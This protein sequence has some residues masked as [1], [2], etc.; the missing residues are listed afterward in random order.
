MLAIFRGRKEIPPAYLMAVLM[1]SFPS[2]L[3]EM[4]R[5]TRPSSESERSQQVSPKQSLLAKSSWI[6][7]LILFSASVVAAQLVERPLITARHAVVTS[8][9][10]LASMAGMR[11][12]QEGGN[13]FDAAVATAV[14]VGVL[15]PRMS[16]IGGNGFATIYVGK[17]H[18]VRALDFYGSAPQR[19]TASLYQG[20]DYSHGF[21]SAPVPSSLKGYE[22]LHKAYGK[23]PWARVLQPAIELAEDGFVIRQG[24]INDMKEYQKLLQEFPSTTKVLQPNGRWP[25]AGEIFRQPDLARTLKDIAKNGADAFYRGPL[26]A[27]IAQFYQANG[28]V[29]SA[30]DLAG[31]QAK[32]IAPI[33]TNYRGYIFYTQPPSSSG[34]AVLE[35]L[36]MLE[37]YDLRALGH[38][39]SEYLHLIGEVMRLAIADRN[40]YVGD[41]DF[42]KVPVEKLLSKSYAAERRKLIHL[43]TT[44]PIAT[45][46]DFDQPDDKHTTHLSVVDDDDNMVAL[47]QTLGDIFGSGVIAADTGVFFSDEMRH[48]HL[49]PND[50]SRL[51]PG[52]RS[53]SNQSPIIVLKDGKPFMTIGTPGSNGI[54]QRIVQV[55]A[56]VIDFGMD[57]QTA[58]TAPRMIYGGRA[59]TGTEFRPVFKVEDRVPLATLDALRSKGYEVISVKDDDGRVN[60]I[61]IDPATGF[62]LGGA[63]PR[64][65]GYA[66]GW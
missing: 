30:E 33:S 48:L 13:A 7:A 65:M 29:L 53:R 51:E 56:N 31:Y 10:P 46:G 60:G 11:I 19:A 62:R 41:P 20:K 37:A 42:V 16:S 24:L 45:A 14:A 26:A 3:N 57:V 5:P 54:W 66:L 4:G 52:K 63:D 44:I 59:E 38:N 15:D 58:I 9:E 1:E 22:A 35:Q 21:L 36:N 28:G 23:L 40:R 18:E 64:E 8:D 27:H 61:V 2:E 25:V 47:T 32:W 34:I 50:P 49:D 6:F 17:T 43:D 12:L 55:I 39:S